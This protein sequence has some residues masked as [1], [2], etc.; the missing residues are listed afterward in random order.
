MQLGRLVEGHP[1]GQNEVGDGE[2]IMV[3]QG[4]WVPNEV[5]EATGT[6]VKSMTQSLVAGSVSISVPDRSSFDIK[7]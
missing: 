4:S 7:A 6:D 1:D 5:T 3:V 2:A